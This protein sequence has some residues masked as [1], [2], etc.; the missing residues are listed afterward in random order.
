MTSNITIDKTSNKKSQRIDNFWSVQQQQ[1]LATGS[2]ATTQPVAMTF[3]ASPVALAVAPV[4][5]AVTATTN[6][7]F[8]LEK[9]QQTCSNIGN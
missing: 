5:Q 2:R 3:V 4:L 1:L 8:L 7:I 9:Q 6:D